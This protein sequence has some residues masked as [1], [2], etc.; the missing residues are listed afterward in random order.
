M[1]FYDDKILP[2]IISCACSMRPIM[3]MREQVVPEAYG[4]VLEIGMGSG[5]NL[6]LYNPQKVSKVWGLEPSI[7]MRKRAAGNLASSPVPVEW[8]ALPGEKIPLPDHSVDCIVLTYT[9]CTIPDWKAALQQMHRVL[10][11]NGQLLFSEHGQSPDPGIQRWQH[12]INPVWKKLMGGCNLNRPV[13]TNIEAM[14]FSLVEHHSEYLKNSPK[15]IGYN[16]LGKAKKA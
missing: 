3:E 16:T 5:L 1:S 11:P 10:K 13:I 6:P 12:R 7:A 9:L 14:G 15:F 2:H 8:L 4:D